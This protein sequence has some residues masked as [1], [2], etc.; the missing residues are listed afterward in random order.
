MSQKRISKELKDLI[1][2]PPRNYSAAPIGEDLFHWSAT[3][4]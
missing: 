4:L 2:N 1:N 3:L